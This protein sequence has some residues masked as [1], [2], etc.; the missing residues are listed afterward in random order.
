MRILFGFIIIIEVF[1]LTI[2]NGR[3]LFYSGNR[4]GFDFTVFA[5]FL[6]LLIGVVL[7]GVLLKKK[8]LNV[9]SKVVLFLS[10]IIVINIFAFD[11]LNI[12]VEYKEWFLRGRPTKP[13]DL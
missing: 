8:K 7:S 11:Y 3:F 5:Y 6:S 12:C 10:V 1:F 13:F 2:F 4:T 9:I